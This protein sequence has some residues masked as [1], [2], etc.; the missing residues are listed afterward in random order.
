MSLL[1]LA[2]LFGS[3]GCDVSNRQQESATVIKVAELKGQKAGIEKE[4][5]LQNN[6]LSDLQ[7]RID[8]VRPGTVLP[9]GGRVL[10]PNPDWF[11]QQ[12]TIRQRLIALE[13]ELAQI[14]EE[15]KVLSPNVS[16]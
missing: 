12:T 16:R 7:Q 2:I 10:G 8:A 6:A 9:G 3:T 4:I 13:S 14:N 15:V 5:E 1:S 11:R